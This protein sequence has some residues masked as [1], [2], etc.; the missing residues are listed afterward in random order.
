MACFK[1][2][3]NILLNAV[4]K[5]TLFAQRGYKCPACFKVVGGAMMYEAKDGSHI[6]VLWPNITNACFIRPLSLSMCL[7]V[8]CWLTCWQLLVTGYQSSY[9]PEVFQY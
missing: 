2:S 8:D 5:M 4:S 1:N 6:Y 9:L 7:L 3:V